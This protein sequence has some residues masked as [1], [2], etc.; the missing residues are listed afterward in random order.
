MHLIL[1]DGHA[2]RNFCKTPDTCTDTRFQASIYMTGFELDQD[3]IDTYKWAKLRASLDVS[4]VQ[5]GSVTVIFDMLSP[6]YG[7]IDNLR[8]LSSTSHVEIPR[9]QQCM[10]A[11]TCPESS[12]SSAT[13]IESCPCDLLSADCRD[14]QCFRKS[15]CAWCADG[16]CDD[17]T[18]GAVSSCPECGEPL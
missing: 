18:A 5:T 1:C 2:N 15:T 11:G 8:I 17:F 13:T 12:T 10:S 14:D 6:H 4:A 7:V 16:C 9:S 3:N